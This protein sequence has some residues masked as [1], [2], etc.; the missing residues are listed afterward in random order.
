[1]FLSTTI[2]LANDQVIFRS[3]KLF[4]L[5]TDQQSTTAMGSDCISLIQ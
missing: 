2:I 1:M 3:Q 5:E 4:S